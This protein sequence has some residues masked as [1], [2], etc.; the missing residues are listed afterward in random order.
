MQAFVSG[1]I[2]AGIVQ[3]VGIR[4]KQGNGAL[5]LAL[6]DEHVRLGEVAGE[7]ALFVGAHAFNVRLA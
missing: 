2:A 1:Q 7:T 3:T 6:A 5:V 4:L